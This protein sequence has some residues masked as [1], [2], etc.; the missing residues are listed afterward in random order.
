MEGDTSEWPVFAA[1]CQAN[2]IR[3]YPARPASVAY[4][5]LDNLLLGID[6]LRSIV[7]SISVAHQNVADPTLGP[8][9]SA[10]LHQVEPIK[11]PRSW[12]DS[13]KRHF[14]ELPYETQ[15][16]FAQHEHKRDKEINRAHQEAAHWRKKLAEI[17]GK[18]NVEETAPTAA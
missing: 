10:A 12:P 18:Q 14:L 4:F 17:E 15:I 2:S 5:I 6:R 7:R 8:A 16:F 9:V 13:E 11:P 3:P 1:W